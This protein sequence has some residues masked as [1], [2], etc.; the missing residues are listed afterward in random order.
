MRKDRTTLSELLDDIDS[1]QGEVLSIDAHSTISQAMKQLADHSMLSAPV[2]VYQENSSDKD[3]QNN[4]AKLE[5]N[6]PSCSYT[7]IGFVDVRGLLGIY[8][9]NAMQE[10]SKAGQICDLGHMDEPLYRAATRVGNMKVSNPSTSG[11]P[12]FQAS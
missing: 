10:L 9:T 1:L 4:N 5:I 2:V 11:T 8:V 12:C 6:F 7:P 3:Q